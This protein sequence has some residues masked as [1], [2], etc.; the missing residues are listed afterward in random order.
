MK[1]GMKNEIGLWF[2]FG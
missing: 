2:R 1:V